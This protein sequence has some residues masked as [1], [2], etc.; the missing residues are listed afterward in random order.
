MA[1]SLFASADLVELTDAYRGAEEE[2]E[3]RST[4]DRCRAIA[5]ELQA[6][7]RPATT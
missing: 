4:M 2:P 6:E 3:Y 5:D 7:Y 1:D